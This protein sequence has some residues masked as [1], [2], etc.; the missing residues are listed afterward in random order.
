[1]INSGYHFTFSHQV[2]PAILRS[3]ANMLFSMQENRDRKQAIINLFDDVC[4]SQ[5]F[6]VSDQE[7]AEIFVEL[8]KLSGYPTILI[9]MP[10]PTMVTQAYLICIV[11][12]ADDKI[13]YFTLEAADGSE[14]FLC[15]LADGSHMNYG[16]V[17][18]KQFIARLSE[19]ISK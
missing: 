7:K 9:T 8:I 2:L 10:Q 14:P 1:M 17:D 11:L 5:G 16:P 18:K 13:R 15:E 19:V 3:G 4:K 12:T 6:T